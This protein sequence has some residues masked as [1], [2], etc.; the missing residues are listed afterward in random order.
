MPWKNNLYNQFTDQYLDEE[1]LNFI[2]HKA[3]KI[4]KKCEKQYMSDEAFLQYYN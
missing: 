3:N 4:R 1:K 2:V